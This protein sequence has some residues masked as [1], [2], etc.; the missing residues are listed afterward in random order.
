MSDIFTEAE[1]AL[2]DPFEK[3]VKEPNITN[4]NVLDP[5]P[6]GFE[7]ID[8][9][10]VEIVK[11]TSTTPD[12]VVEDIEVPVGESDVEDV[13][14]ELPEYTYE[15][16]LIDEQAEKDIAILLDFECIDHDFSNSD[17]DRISNFH[18]FKSE[19]F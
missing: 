14:L 19:Y 12:A 15:E 3:T 5:C 4:N 1:I 16:L 11:T 13:A 8:G 9:K 18:E 10:C 2:F 6:A 7:R 17:I